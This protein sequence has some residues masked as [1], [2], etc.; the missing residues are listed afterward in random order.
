MQETIAD[1]LLAAATPTVT[2]RI[3]PVAE[4]GFTAECV[5]IPGCCSEGETEVEAETN[6]RKAIDACLSVIFEDSLLRIRSTASINMP[7]PSRP[8]K[9]EILAITLPRLAD[10]AA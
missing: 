1:S 9:L 2:V 7:E 10:E 6:I 4:G 5:E 3:M 8:V